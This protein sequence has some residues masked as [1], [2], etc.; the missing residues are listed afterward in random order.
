MA[1]ARRVEA[2]P[3]GSNGKSTERFATKDSPPQRGQDPRN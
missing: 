1:E 2:R 3:C